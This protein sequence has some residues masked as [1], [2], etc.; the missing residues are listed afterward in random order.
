MWSQISKEF[1]TWADIKSELMVYTQPYSHYSIYR[2][3]SIVYVANFPFLLAI[4]ICLL[5][6]QSPLS[7]LAAPYRANWEAEEGRHSGRVGILRAASFSRILHRGLFLGDWKLE[8]FFFKYLED[9][10]KED[11]QHMI[12]WLLIKALL[13][14]GTGGWERQRINLN[15]IL[16]T[17]NKK[18]RHN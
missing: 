6:R 16:F 15:L 9:Q 10:R 18:G 7:T 4:R 8:N 13:E 17:C 3:D 5:S 11:N 2:R 14:G 1:L 12:N